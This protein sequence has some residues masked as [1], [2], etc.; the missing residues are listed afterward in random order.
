MGKKWGEG[1]EERERE[2]KM[3]EIHDTYNREYPRNT[4]RARKREKIN[5]KVISNSNSR[6]RRL[7][8]AT[9]HIYIP[10]P[11]LSLPSSTFLT[12]IGE[13]SEI[14]VDANG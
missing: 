1:G 8:L 12:V 2:R 9:Y 5:T 4:Q 7:P 14:L 13:S 3:K 10:V 11:F 6:R